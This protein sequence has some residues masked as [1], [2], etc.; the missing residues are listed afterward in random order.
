M[1]RRRATGATGA[2]ATGVA[3]AGS[4][5]GGA[6]AGTTF[7]VVA[8]VVVARAALGDHGRPVVPAGRVGAVSTG[9]VVR[10]AGSAMA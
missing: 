9:P 8:G 2:A 1:A 3:A 10:C 7:S 5:T 4:V 6:V